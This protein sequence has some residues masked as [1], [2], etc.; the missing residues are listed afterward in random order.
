MKRIICIFIALV[1]LFSVLFSVSASAKTYK[2][3]ET[4]MSIQLDESLW[5]VFTREN[6]NNNSVLDELDISYDTIYKVLYNNDAYMDALMIYDEGDYLEFFIRKKAL[7]SGVSNLSNYK[8]SEV[9]NLARK[10]AK[11]QGADTYS[12]F[13]NSYKFARIEYIDPE[14]GFYICEFVTIVNKNNYTLTFQSKS[15]FTEAEYEEIDKIVNSIH[16]DV[17]TSLTESKTA[18]TL[19]KIIIITVAGALIGG[20]A[21]AVFIILKKN[22]K[23]HNEK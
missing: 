2:L 10:L 23:Q 17:D 4:D 1:S 16:F 11:Q 22:K 9:L 6:I 8:E 12:V 5:H 3:E 19:G 14:F 13:G 18:S 20:A 7:N 21:G 15:K